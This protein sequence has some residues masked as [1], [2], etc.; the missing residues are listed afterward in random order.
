VFWLLMSFLGHYLNTRNHP[1]NAAA[2]FC[3]KDLSAS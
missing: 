1:E 2:I 3:V